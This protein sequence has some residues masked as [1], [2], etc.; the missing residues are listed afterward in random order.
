VRPVLASVRLTTERATVVTLVYAS[1]VTVT[2]WRIRLPA[3]LRSGLSSQS[4]STTRHSG[5]LSLM[6]VHW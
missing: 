6:L 1:T 3:L 4:I 5:A 2:S